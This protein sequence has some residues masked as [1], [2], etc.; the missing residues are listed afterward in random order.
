MYSHDL[1]C[2]KC[3]QS[4]NTCVRAESGTF[5]WLMCFLLCCVGCWLG[6]CIIPFY[7]DACKDYY[8]HCGNKECN[9]LLAVKK[10]L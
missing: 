10:T 8:H 5:A 6:C 3:G 4:N 9:Q 2:W 1:A 7:V